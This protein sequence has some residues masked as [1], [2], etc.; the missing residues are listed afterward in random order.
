MKSVNEIYNSLADNFY[1][2]TKL[3]FRE[4]SILDKFSL[5]I[6][7]T[8][9]YIYEE[10]EKIKNPHIYTN[11]SGSDIDSEGILVGCS[12]EPKED[13]N[14]FLYRMMKWNTSNQC[15]NLTAINNK[16]INLTYASHAEFVP[17]T[18]GVSTGT[19]YVIPLKLN[20]E[21]EKAAIEEVKDKLKDV[22][23]GTSYV[24]YM[25]PK[26]L[27]VDLNCYLSVYKDEDNIKENI[28]AAMKDYI[29]NIAPGDY[30]EVGQLNK[31]GTNTENVN[32]FNISEVIIDGE[33]L[34][35]LQRIQKLQ[36]KFVFGS[37]NWNMVVR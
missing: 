22:L 13:D 12:R 19:V 6:A 15:A 28:A 23:S 2:F 32:Y 34:L 16:L 31:I 30:I 4:G 35:D 5:A 7:V 10:I 24:D 36:D 17:Y 8:F 37:I 21:T 20:E 14:T 1:K 11:L 26:I 18:S 25:I 27:E 33:Q 29:N 3:K 9:H